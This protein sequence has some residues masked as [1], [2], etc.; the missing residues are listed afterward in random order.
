MTLNQSQFNYHQLLIMKRKL[1]LLAVLLGQ[2]ITMYCQIDNQ[3]AGQQTYLKYS[4]KNRN[5]GRELKYLEDSTITQNYD[6]AKGW[7]LNNKYT[8]VYDKNGNA[9]LIN[10]FTASNNKF[11]TNK[12]YFGSYNAE[13][14]PVQNETQT[15]NV[16]NKV[17]DKTAIDTTIYEN[18]KIKQYSTK[19]WNKTTSLYENSYKEEYQYDSEGNE[20]TYE[21]LIW[22]KTAQKWTGSAKNTKGYNAQNQLIETNKFN[23]NT[24]TQQYDATSKETHLVDSENRIIET[25][26]FKYDQSGGLV[27]D[28]KTTNKYGFDIDTSVLYTYDA[29]L[30]SFVPSTRLSYGYGVNEKLIRMTTEL[31]S[32]SDSKWNISILWNYTLD[33]NGNW[34]EGIRQNALAGTLTL[35]RKT[36]YYYT[37][38][39]LVANSTLTSPAI[40]IYPNPSNGHLTVS[41]LSDFQNLSIYTLTGTL[42][43]SRS[44]NQNEIFLDLSSYSAGS[45]LL[46]LS[47][48]DRTIR[49]QII[50][51]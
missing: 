37:Q 40:E 21:F 15:W 34:D 48:N 20:V 1:L 13:N 29:N 51:N 26:A 31:Y 38:Y 9:T 32:K 16:V 12:R 39:N 2:C 11:V 7:L 19:L 30:L 5:F 44:L 27:P 42:V 46:V 28:S 14:Q 50:K 35:S 41:Q 24:L 33:S 23:F 18:K 36:K 3:D 17:W 47:G 43:L 6:N 22:D 8:N 10:Y 25:T 49:A 45:Y 4:T